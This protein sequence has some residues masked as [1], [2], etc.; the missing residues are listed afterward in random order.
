MKA[1]HRL[2]IL[3]APALLTL[4][5][6]EIP[7]TG[8]VEAGGP[9][10]GIT[11][12]TPVYFV[13]D[14]ALVAVPRTTARPGDAEAALQ[15]LL[16]GPTPAEADGHLSSEMPGKPAEVPQALASAAPESA[17]ASPAPR[18]TPPDGLTVSLQGDALSIRLPPGFGKLSRL[19]TEQLVCTAA[20]AHRIGHPFGDT[21]TVTVSDV[22]GWHAEGTDKDCP[23]PRQPTLR[24][25]A[26]P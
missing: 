1:T 16:I 12:I 10:S 13:L 15:M 5:A 2:A 11:P 6:C 20:A 19:A 8:V 14:G 3:I 23:D 22:S 21:V 26:R 7:T 4:C 25:P 9:A 24:P 17:P 18:Q